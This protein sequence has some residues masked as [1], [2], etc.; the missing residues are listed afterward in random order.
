VRRVEHIALVKAGI[1]TRKKALNEYSPIE[2]VASFVSARAF[3]SDH[4]YR[5]DIKKKLRTKP[6]LSATIDNSIVPRNY[7][8]VFRILKNG[9]TFE[10]PFFTKVV[11]D[12]VYR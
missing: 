7:T 8:I 2:R 1:F 9:P 11:I 6:A 4:K 3:L 12:E 5:T 10:L